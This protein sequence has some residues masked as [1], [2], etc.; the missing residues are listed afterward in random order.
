MGMRETS[1]SIEPGE[2]IG[3][4]AENQ[5]PPRYLVRLENGQELEAILPLSIR[6]KVGCLFGPLQAGQPVR[7][8]LME[9]P[10]PHRI[11]DLNHANGRLHKGL[12]GPVRTVAPVTHTI[13][14]ERATPMQLTLNGQ[15]HDAPDGQTVADLIAAL[16]H[17]PKVG[18]AVEV[19]REV[20]PK[21]MHAT[22]TLRDGDV[23]EIVTLV[24][25]G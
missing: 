3:L 2:V 11:V 8:K 5:T 14:I 19:N 13:E 16:D 4:K 25:G 1:G 18:V 12:A 20:V 9:S 22:T 23:V 7:V 10:R 17:L 15:P 21:A 24:G 6:S